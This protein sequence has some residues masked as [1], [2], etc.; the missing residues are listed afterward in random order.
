VWLG[1]R[2]GESR[3]VD[4]SEGL[5]DARIRNGWAVADDDPALRYLVRA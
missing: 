5:L 4:D 2:P 1:L 3:E